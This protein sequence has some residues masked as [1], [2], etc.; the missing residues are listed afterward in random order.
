MLVKIYITNKYLIMIKL[1]NISI[2]IILLSVIILSVS[3][4]AK[5]VSFQGKWDTNMGTLFM[6]QTD[7]QVRGTYSGE[8]GKLWGTVTG[9]T[10]KGKYIWKGKEGVFEFTMDKSGKSFTGSWSRDISGGKWT[11]TK[12]A[13]IENERDVTDTDE[14]HTAIDAEGTWNTNMGTLKMYQT[15]NE[16][17]G[18]YSGGDG[19]MW[20]KING[21]KMTGTYKWKG[22]EGT[23]EFIFNSD[24]NNFTGSWERDI[25]SGKWTGTKKGVKEKQKK[26]KPVDDLNVEG[27]W[28]TNLG[29]LKMYQTGNEISGTYSNGDGKMWGTVSGKKMKGTY[30][31]K[32]K[33]GT[34][35]FEFD[36]QAKNFTGSWKRNNT[37]GKWTGSRQ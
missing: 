17:S 26:T 4:I 16:V 36:S 13:D 32:G 10:L 37:E 15:G 3:G 12:I 5:S 21:N 8:N 33:S 31:W 14:N 11:G 18:T 28:R 19:K 35:E 25:S 24:G 30:T 29:T 20:G 7:N 22:K 23:F 34:F 9:L 6:Y 1:K 2:T 27:T